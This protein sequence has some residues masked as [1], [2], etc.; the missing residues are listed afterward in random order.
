M[1]FPSVALAVLGLTL[2]IRLASNSQKSTCLC[3]RVLG[4][5]AYTFTAQLLFENINERKEFI[6]NSFA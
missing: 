2:W 4:L 3:L 5:K 1:E 6:S